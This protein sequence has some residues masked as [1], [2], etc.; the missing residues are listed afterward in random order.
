[1]DTFVYSRDPEQSTKAQLLRSI[2][3]THVAS[4]TTSI[5]EFVERLGTIDFVYEATA[6]NIFRSIISSRSS[7]RDG[8]PMTISP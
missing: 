5:A 8:E 4:E 2:G 6:T 7:D 1:M 3:A